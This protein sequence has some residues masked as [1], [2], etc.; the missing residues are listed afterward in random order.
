MCISY[1][2]AERTIRSK[3]IA[4]ILK[5]VDKIANILCADSVI[6][7]DEQV[8]IK[9]GLE[10]MYN[11]LLGLA[12]TLV[13]SAVFASLVEGLLLWI[14][15]F[16]LR[17]YAGG[18]HAKTKGKCIVVS[19]ALLII[20]FGVWNKNVCLTWQYVAISQFLCLII[21]FIAPIDNINKSLDKI[22]VYVYKNKV[23]VLLTFQELIIVFAILIECE[24]LF[25]IITMCYL[26]VAIVVIA[27]M[28][29]SK[30]IFGK[31][32]NREGE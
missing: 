31:K 28:L 22:E 23:R 25:G 6:T 3:K 1:I 19:I 24:R 17:K 9:Y 18:Y 27:E 12:I 13:V 32:D 7:E 15:L 11:N 5:I 30:M 16:P 14:I 2:S 26:I 8:I 20:A 21:F 4:E 10:M 29:N